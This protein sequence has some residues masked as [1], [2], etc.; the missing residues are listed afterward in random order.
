[1]KLLELF[2]EL[3]LHPKNAEELKGLILQLAV[4]GKLTSKWRD[5]HPEV[6]SASVLLEK[7]REEKKQL[8]KKKK[9]RQEKTKIELAQHLVEFAIPTTWTSAN[10]T[11]VYYTIGNKKNQINASQYLEQGS[12]PIVSQGKNLI[13]GYSNDK[14][15][16][17][18]IKKPVVV[19]GD[20][21]RVVK[22]IDFDFIIGADG[23][24][25]LFSLDGVVSDY[26]Y[27]YV[28]S[29]DLSNRGYARHYSILKNVPFPLPPLEE[30]KAIVE[31]VNQLFAEVEQLETL[32]KERIQLKEDFVVSALQRLSNGDTAKEWSFLQEHFKTFFTEKSNVKKLREAV[33][34]LAVQGKLTT[35]WRSTNP[36]A[37][38]ASELLKRIK[39]EKEQLI[40]EKK[41]KKEKPLPSITKDEIPYE[42]PEGW[43]WCRLGDILLYSDSGKSP[44]CE[45]R[46]VEGNEWGVLTTTAI[47]KNRFNETANKV[48]PVGFEIKEQQIVHSGDILITRAGPI[49]RAG[50][51]C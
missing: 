35:K 12:Y 2:K 32:T 38:P 17:I 24:K 36:N 1:M 14:A 49:N 48:L 47:Q 44:N 31:V 46:P 6:Q 41:I 43:V 13:D 10:I 11:E 50:I 29:I 4:Q 42:L 34:Q 28:S 7:I 27:F 9:I 33:L 3:T 25:I 16:L 21:T 18:E 15:K 40:K 8:I 51:A 37:E 45:K 5:E 26:F 30:Q 39:V 19:F 22:I 20:H 23:T